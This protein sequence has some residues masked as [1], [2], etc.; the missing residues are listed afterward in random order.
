[1]KSHYPGDAR[2][3]MGIQR[4]VCLHPFEK[5]DLWRFYQMLHAGHVDLTVLPDG[6]VS[7]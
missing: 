7:V 1:M 2:E 5:Y 3:V 6:L 4:E